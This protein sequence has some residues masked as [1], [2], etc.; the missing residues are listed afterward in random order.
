MS[1]GR[2]PVKI[3]PSTS[4]S[5]V[6]SSSRGP[7]AGL[8]G[9]LGSSSGLSS[10]YSRTRRLLFLAGSCAI[11]EDEWRSDEQRVAGGCSGEALHIE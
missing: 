10:S 9:Q 2:A 3:L 4:I 8:A 11:A 1:E 6:A 7:V 5:G